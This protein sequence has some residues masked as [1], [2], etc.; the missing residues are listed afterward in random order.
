[1]TA[2]P[3]AGLGRRMIL[4]CLA[5]ATV[6]ALSPTAALAD[7]RPQVSGQGLPSRT[8]A[9][10]QLAARAAWQLNAG[11]QY[12]SAY[13]RWVKAQQK[14][15]AVCSTTGSVPNRRHTCIFR[16]NPCS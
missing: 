14:Q 4:P 7:C 13:A 16:A 5:I 8:N 11:N 6:L 12:G 1:M 9:A 15:A 2:L 10:A 3:H